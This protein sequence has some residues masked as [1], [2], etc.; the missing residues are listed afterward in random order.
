EAMTRPFDYLFGNHG[1]IKCGLQFQR[2][3]LKTDEPLD[4]VA[5][6]SAEYTNEFYKIV[7]K[8]GKF[9]AVDSDNKQL[10]PFIYEEAYFKHYED[11]IMVAKENNIWYE[12]DVTANSRFEIK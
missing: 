11:F 9:G 10:I 7:Y 1:F 6:P 12:I 3:V 5:E 8:A 4:L 2:F